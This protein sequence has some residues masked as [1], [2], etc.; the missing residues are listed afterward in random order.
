VTYIGQAHD[1]VVILKD[2]P[3]LEEGTQVRVEVPEEACSK[4]RPGSADAILAFMRD[5]NNSWADSAAEMDDALEY[6]R[7]TKWED[8]RRQLSEPEKTL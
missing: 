3:K 7:K 1:G 8:L 6:L 5:S 4:P 2:A